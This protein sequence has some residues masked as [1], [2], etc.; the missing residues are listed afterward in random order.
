MNP[1]AA[2]AKRVKRRPMGLTLDPLITRYVHERRSRG[3]LTEY[4]ARKHERNLRRFSLV[5]GRR[6]IERLSTVDVERW[7]A[8]HVKE[9]HKPATIRCYLSEVRGFINWCRRKQY[10]KHDPMLEVR[11]PKLPRKMVQII[12]RDDVMKVLAVCP[13]NRATAIIWLMYVCGVRCVEVARLDIEDWNRTGRAL[14]VV[15]KG[16]HEREIP[17]MPVVADALDAYLSDFP[18]S[19][20]PFFRSYVKP[21]E[22]VSANYLGELVA[23]W[24]RDAGVKLRAYDGVSA[25]AFRRT[26]ATELLRVTNDLTSTQELLGHANPATLAPYLQRANVERVRAALDHRLAEGDPATEAQPA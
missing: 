19:S 26:A 4:T 5:F 9:G 2:P 15:G 12:E 7:I 6:P 11:P 23:G 16:L 21:G 3:E 24:Q 8:G 1:T 17:V 13:D 14:R 18:A 25:H 10:I 22:R 20:G